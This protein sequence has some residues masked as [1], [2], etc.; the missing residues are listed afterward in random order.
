MAQDRA[1]Y[2]EH[3]ERWL[4]YEDELASPCLAAGAQAPLA[5]PKIANAAPLRQCKDSLVSLPSC[6]RDEEGEGVA[7]DGEEY[8]GRESAGLVQTVAKKV[9]TALGLKVD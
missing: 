6:A 4:D 1:S 9:K 2:L 3:L 7:G 8:D 5:K